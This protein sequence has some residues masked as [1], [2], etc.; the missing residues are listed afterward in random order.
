MRFVSHYIIII[1]ITG[2]SFH[3]CITY[4]GLCYTLQVDVAVVEVSIGGTND[5][6]NI[7]P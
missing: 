5:S 4:L 7:I 2:I 3:G 1:D 6:T